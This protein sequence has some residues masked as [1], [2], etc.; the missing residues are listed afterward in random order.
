MPVLR[1]PEVPLAPV[2]LHMPLR[3]LRR[4]LAHGRRH[5]EVGGEEWNER[6]GKN[7]GDS[8]ALAEFT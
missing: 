4:K 7:D 3:R 2:R 6:K 1:A 5:Q 8:K